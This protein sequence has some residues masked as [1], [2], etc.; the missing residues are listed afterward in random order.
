MVIHGEPAC[1]GWPA[2]P[3]KSLVPCRGSV[4][5]CLQ[6]FA[7]ALPPV[8][9]A[10]PAFMA[11]ALGPGTPV[12]ALLHSIYPIQCAFVLFASGSLPAL[13]ARKDKHPAAPGAPHCFTIVLG[14]TGCVGAAMSSDETDSEPDSSANEDIDTLTA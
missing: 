10:L 5:L 13:Q 12:C 9:F 3:A 2:W 6:V 7:T 1:L 11:F 8:L 4:L 14:N